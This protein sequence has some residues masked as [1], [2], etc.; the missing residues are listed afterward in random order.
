[1][2]DS[3]KQQSSGYYTRANSLYEKGEPKTALSAIDQAITTWPYEIEYYLLKIKLLTSLG[4]NENALEISIEA[5]DIDSENVKALCQKAD[6]LYK[7]KRIDEAT[8][9]YSQVLELKPASDLAHYVRG[10]IMHN[11]GLYKEASFEYQKTLTLNPKYHQAYYKLGLI[12]S[13]FHLEQE[14]DIYKKASDHDPSNALYHNCCGH[15]AYSIGQKEDALNYYTKALELNKED[16]AYLYNIAIVSFEIE[17]KENAK[18]CYSQIL[19]GKSIIEE[20]ESASQSPNSLDVYLTFRPNSTI[21]V[22]YIGNKAMALELLGEHDAA[23]MMYNKAIE[24]DPDVFLIYHNQGKILYSS[25]KYEEAI[26]CFNLALSLNIS[27]LNTYLYTILSYYA[28][29]ND[30]AAKDLFIA[31]NGFGQEDEIINFISN[32]HWEVNDPY[33]PKEARIL[34]DLILF[35]KNYEKGFDVLEKN[36]NFNLKLVP[37]N[38]ISLSVAILQAHNC[39]LMDRM[40]QTNQNFDEVLRELILELDDISSFKLIQQICF[41]SDKIAN[42]VKAG[43]IKLLEVAITNIK[44][45]LAQYLLGLNIDLIDQIE[46]RNTAAE[47]MIMVKNKELSCALQDRFNF[48]LQ[49]KLKY[50]IH[51][52]DIEL[53]NNILIISPELLDTW[54][55]DMPLGHWVLKYSNKDIMELI[56]VNDLSIESKTD[57]QGCDLLTVALMKQR[58]DIIE[59]LIM[60][61][62]FGIDRPLYNMLQSTYAVINISTLILQEALN[63]QNISVLLSHPRAAAIRDNQNNTALHIAVKYNNEEFIEDYL[64][65]LSK[66]VNEQNQHGQTPLHLLL[67]EFCGSFAQ[68]RI[69]EQLLQMKDINIA[70]ADEKGFTPVDIAANFAPYVLKKF[71]QKQLISQAE[72]IDPTYDKYLPFVVKMSDIRSIK[73]IQADVLKES[74]P[75]H[76]ACFQGHEQEVERLLNSEE[77]YNIPDLWGYFPLY[78]AVSQSNLE[79]V[80]ILAS[81]DNVDVIR[82]SNRLNRTSILHTAINEDDSA[83]IKCLFEKAISLEEGISNLQGE[84]H[85]ALIH[86]VRSVKTASY[87][88]NLFKSLTKK[89]QAQYKLLDLNQQDAYGHTALYYASLLP[90]PKLMDYWFKLSIRH[91]QQYSIDMILNQNLLYIAALK[92]NTE[93]ISYLL[94]RHKDTFVLDSHSNGAL[95]ETS[96]CGQGPDTIKFL[97]HNYPESYLL[98]KDPARLKEMA[99]FFNN[100]ALLEYFNEA[101][102]LSILSKHSELQLLENIKEVKTEFQNKIQELEKKCTDMK[103]VAENVLLRRGSGSFDGI[104]LMQPFLGTIRKK[105]SNLEKGF[106]NIQEQQQEHDEIMLLSGVD[107]RARIQKELKFFKDSNSKLHDYCTAFYYGLSTYFM[108]YKTLSTGNIQTSED[109]SDTAA[110]YGISIL[111][112]VSKAISKGIPIVGG[113]VACLDLIIIGTYSSIQTWKLQRKIQIINEIIKKKSPLEDELSL[114]IVKTAVAVTKIKIQEISQTQEQNKRLKWIDSKLKSIKDNI[115]GA[116]IMTTPSAAL[117]MQ[118]VGAILSNMYQNYDRVISDS[119]P[120]DDTLIAFALTTKPVTS[121]LRRHEA[122]RRSAFNLYGYSKVDG[123]DLLDLTKKD[124]EPLKVNG[125]HLLDLTK[126]Q[127]KLLGKDS[128]WSFDST[129]VSES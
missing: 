91:P 74:Y 76:Y 28:L 94:K 63:H 11:Q 22:E 36:I 105:L 8:A 86:E 102:L 95:V 32:L 88:V 72:L 51:H 15:A 49:D 9:V 27:N 104:K 57:N 39:F 103:Y 113:V 66:M 3:R 10:S 100:K 123:I 90:D 41:K 78:Y 65:D 87:L 75:L 129:D 93:I 48:D 118:D 61:Y 37:E 26:T 34:L 29:N 44:P 43:Q 70:I 127:P 116:D 121:P 35:S 96:I 101:R 117:A 124:P 115:I 38:S 89:N 17:M 80:K 119:K 21:P 1:M 125:V 71:Y 6:L 84:F 13:Y 18:S 120:L 42:Q 14:L 108:A 92:G 98:I 20:L 99:I 111:M 59:L 19:K 47:C 12:C 16:K 52:K 7:L 126:P 24:V 55:D 60:K 122:R 2:F 62:N 81:K 45:E 53:V 5:L 30:A 107:E 85:K 58:F 67:N 83:V 4:R 106:T 109:I 112:K 69:L 33:I 31:L 54:F 40:L 68:V 23:V 82:A 25:K 50:A 73:N 128:M 56:L 79:A 64:G 110:K 114:N 77:N 46:D 97:F